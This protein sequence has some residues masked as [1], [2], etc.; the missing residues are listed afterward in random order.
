MATIRCILVVAVKKSWGLYQL[1]G[2]NAF[3]HGDLN[4]E[5]YMK[6]LVGFTPPSPNHVLYV[7]D[8]LLIGND[9]KELTELKEF[10]HQEFRIKD[11]GHLHYFLGM[12]VLRESHGLILSQR[13]FTLDLLHEFDSLHKSPVSC[14]LDPSACLLAQTE[15]EYRSMRRVVAE[16]TWLVR[17]FDYLSTP[18]SLLVPLHSDSQTAIH[19]ARNN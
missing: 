9:T 4:E 11:L 6:F 17:L 3:L 7:G 13:K 18:I 12:E 2:N 16:L 8:I 15:A 5:V 14:P 1:D 10:L 19:I